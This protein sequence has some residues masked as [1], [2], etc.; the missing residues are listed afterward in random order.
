MY[1][2]QISHEVK[3]DIMLPYGDVVIALTLVIV[4]HVMLCGGVS[5]LLSIGTD[6]VKGFVM[7]PGG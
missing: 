6:N 7:D 5:C 2:V 1:E 3:T 4:F